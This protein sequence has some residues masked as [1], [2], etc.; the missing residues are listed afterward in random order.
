MASEGSQYQ[1]R[2]QGT[3]DPSWSDRLCGMTIDNHTS[4]DGPTSTLTGE[5][6][7]QCALSGV[8]NALVDLHYEVLSVDRLEDKPST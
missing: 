1:I 4:E 8:L 5:L 7:D 2:I 3:L 6:A